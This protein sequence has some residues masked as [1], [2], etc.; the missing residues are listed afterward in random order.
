[1]QD[2]M[3]SEEVTVIS[4]E[5]ERST[6]QS[7]L[8]EASDWLYEEGEHAETRVCFYVNPGCCYACL[9]KDSLM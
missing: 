4:T 7:A 3:Y 2:F 6:M 1:M 5:E 9:Y 8:A